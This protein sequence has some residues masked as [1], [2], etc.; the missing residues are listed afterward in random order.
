MKCLRLFFFLNVGKVTICSSD[1]EQ[2]NKHTT[3]FSACAALIY[4]ASA[5][6][7]LLV[8]QCTYISFPSLFLMSVLQA[9]VF[10]GLHPKCVPN[11]A[12]WHAGSRHRVSSNQPSRRWLM[13]G[14][15]VW[16]LMK[17][18]KYSSLWR[19]A[20]LNAQRVS[21]RPCTSTMHSRLKKKK[22]PMEKML[23]YTHW[24]LNLESFF[25]L[26]SLF[27]RISSS[28]QNPLSR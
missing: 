16:R 12:G 9:D 1:R 26:F 24:S 19:I 22:N 5:F 7:D 13:P 17:C 11:P 18:R 3:C 15:F 14:L 4:E 27:W 23:L 20:I 25:S 2:G 10:E 28:L 8:L 21:A 6:P